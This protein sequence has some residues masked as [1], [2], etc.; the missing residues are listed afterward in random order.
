VYEVATQNYHGIFENIES[1]IVF[2]VQILG[3]SIILFLLTYLI[4]KLYRDSIS[5]SDTKSIESDPT[6]DLSSNDKIENSI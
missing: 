5:S 1:I 3:L 4:L 6:T 2:T